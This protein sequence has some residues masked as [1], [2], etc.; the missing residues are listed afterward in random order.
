MQRVK[1]RAPARAQWLA[2]CRGR[3]AAAQPR[4]REAGNS[5]VAFD[6]NKAGGL[7]GGEIKPSIVEEMRVFYEEVG[8]RSPG[9]L[10][11]TVRRL[12]RQ[13]C[14]VADLAAALR[15]LED[16]VAPEDY[17]VW[18]AYSDAVRAVREGSYAPV[19]EAS[20]SVQ[21]QR[22]NQV[23]ASIGRYLTD[24]REKFFESNPGI[25]AEDAACG[26]GDIKTLPEP[27]QRLQAERIRGGNQPQL[28]VLRGLANGLFVFVSQPLGGGDPIVV[29]VFAADASPV[30]WGKLRWP[31]GQKHVGP[32]VWGKGHKVPPHVW[33]LLQR[34][35][36]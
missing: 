33:P 32:L 23:K 31:D 20:R 21:V 5:C 4:S 29:E 3:P 34:K 17:G 6:D 15:K 16:S 25:T 18:Q 36:E 12:F 24:N 1:V 2:I 8:N 13:G 27:I 7:M 26:P 19:G 28:D 11:Q 35:P 9:V 10:Q 22:D 30:T 14:S